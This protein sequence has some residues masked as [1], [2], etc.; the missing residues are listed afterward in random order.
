MINAGQFSRRFFLTFILRLVPLNF[1]AYS[2]F[3]SW[4]DRCRTGNYYLIR[5]VTLAPSKQHCNG[6]HNY[7]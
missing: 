7:Y 1:P 4:F 2:E 5:K 3:F 6:R